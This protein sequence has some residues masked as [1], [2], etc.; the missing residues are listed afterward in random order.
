[1][2]DEK[3][4]DASQG[5]RAHPRVNSFNRVHVIPEDGTP[6]D[7]FS[8]NVS[9]GGMFLRSNL[10]LP[11]GKKVKLEFETINGMVRV[12]E[13]QIVW[14]RPFDPASPGDQVSGMGVKFQSMSE[15]SSKKIETFIDEILDSPLPP[16]S[17]L[18]KPTSAAPHQP[19]TSPAG[20]SM[21]AQS[22]APHQDP[23]SSAGSPSWPKTPVVLA[24]PDNS[25]PPGRTAPPVPLPLPPLPSLPQTDIE[26]NS[27]LDTQ[28]TTEEVM[29]SLYPPPRKRVFLFVGFVLFVAMVTFLTMMIIKPS[30]DDGSGLS[31]TGATSKTV[32]RSQ[33][34][35]VSTADAKKSEPTDAGTATTS[36]KP[37]PAPVQA[38]GNGVHPSK[39][40]KAEPNEQP[41]LA[42]IKETATD[43]L[44]VGPPV[45]EQRPNG[46]R[47]VIRASRAVEIKHFALNAPPRLAIDFP[48]ASFSAK[49]SPVEAPLPSVAK[50]R[51]GKQDWGVRFVLD[52]QGAEAPAYKINVEPASITVSFSQ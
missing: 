9:R 25:Q 41:G 7:V 8:S 31:G 26:L 3:K 40:S 13:G 46:W 48:K 38:P 21:S 35:T 23:P 20:V 24:P 18:N 27:V 44:E 16:A 11:T 22:T 1:M 50:V 17:P 28:P 30:A 52:F 4:K 51:V 49:F 32:S 43:Q 29:T 5:T 45:F 39:V 42:N 14:N 47:M 6:M 19:A 2:A 37:S 12:D 34:S 36:T 33:P 10:P 15:E